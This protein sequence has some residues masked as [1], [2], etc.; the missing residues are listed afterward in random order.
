MGGPGP[1]VRKGFRN[2]TLKSIPDTKAASPQITCRRAGGGRHKSFL[3]M[4]RDECVADTILADR[5]ARAWQAGIFTLLEWRTAEHR[6]FPVRLRSPRR[7]DRPKQLR[8]NQP[9]SVLSDRSGHH[10]RETVICVHAYGRGVV[11]HAGYMRTPQ[12][13]GT[14]ALIKELPNGCNIRRTQVFYGA[15]C[16]NGRCRARMGHFGYVFSVL[17]SRAECHG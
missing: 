5:S 3:V 14:M 10:N 16:V 15:K 4:T 7:S 11:R 17:A 1:A 6:R 9:T 8:I 13:R 2:Q 12:V